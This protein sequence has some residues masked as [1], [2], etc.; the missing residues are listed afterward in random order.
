M[1]AALARRLEDA[2]R[3]DVEMD[4]HIEVDD[5]L[6]LCHRYVDNH[7]SGE[8]P[9]AL[10]AV[11]AL[12]RTGISGVAN[13]LPFTCLPGT[14]V[15][16]VSGSLRKDHDNLPWVDIAFDGQQDASIETRLQ[17]FMHQARE[18]ALRHEFDRPRQWR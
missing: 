8:P 1:Q 5:M 14:L 12:A 9:I 4:R 11:V 10:G 13:V 16:A 2:V 17:A 15:M 7:Y 18:F 3:E 6:K